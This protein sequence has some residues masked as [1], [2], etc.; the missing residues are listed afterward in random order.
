MEVLQNYGTVNIDRSR[1]FNSNFKGDR[2][3]LN[4]GGVTYRT[5][6]AT[7]HNYPN[8]RL[9]RLT[10]SDSS[11]DAEE[12][13]FYFDRNHGFFEY[14]LEFYRTGVLHI[15]KTVCSEMIR[16]EMEFWEISF[17]RIG[18]CC[19]DAYSNERMDKE[20]LKVSTSFLSYSHFDMFI[21]CFTNVSSVLFH[22]YYYH[23]HMCFTM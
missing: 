14:V 7:L 9:G 23:F 20:T 16:N 5:T 21:L 10:T 8:S 4:V 12:E 15:P 11:Y 18:S 17:D 3:L 22:Y 1:V 6:Y 19:L 13:E 2:V